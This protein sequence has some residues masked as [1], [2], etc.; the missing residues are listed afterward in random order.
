MRPFLGKTSIAVL[1]CLPFSGQI[2]HASGWNGSYSAQGQCYCIGELSL[3]LSGKIVPTPV[4]G[5]TISQVCKRVGDGPEL[6]RA[7]GL[8]NFPVYEDPQCGNGPYASGEAP[9]DITCAGSLD[10]EGDS[11]EA[12]GPKWDLDQAFS[13]VSS[14]AAVQPLVE[15]DT[16]IEGVLINPVVSSVEVENNKA[17]VG[18]KKTLKATIIK[19]QSTAGN[20][21]DPGESSPKNSNAIAIEAFTGKSVT[22]DGQRYLQANSEVPAS[23][24]KP[25]SR[26]ILDDLV[27]LREDAFLDPSDL[28]QNE[29]KPSSAVTAAVKA[30]PKVAK[31]S[32]DELATTR[33]IESKRTM[34]LALKA[35]NARRDERVAIKAPA[36]AQL[37]LQTKIAATQKAEL[38][39]QADLNVQAEQ[40][41]KDTQVLNEAETEQ[42]LLKAQA[43]Q[44]QREKEISLKADA[45][46]VQKNKQALLNAEAEQARKNREAQ[47]LAA[48]KQRQKAVDGATAQVKPA[49]SVGSPSA[50]DA[51]SSDNVS[52]LLTALRL[53][54][55]VRQSARDFGYLEAMPVSYDVGGNGV[56]LE[57]SASSHTRFQYVGRLS[58]TAGYQEV[59]I[60]G[61]YYIT[62]SVADRLTV[63]LVAGLEYGSFELSDDQLSVDFDDSGVY[64]GAATRIVLNERFELKGGV[65]YSTFFE[66]DPMLFGGGYYHINRRLDVVSRFELGDNDLLGIGVRF[67]Y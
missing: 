47:R 9:Q 5:Q 20:S 10:G 48:E 16:S 64:L 14:S 63:V 56:L 31:P 2:A 29:Q 18:E 30:E 22:L 26:I 52:T 35:Q 62:P 65:G 36:E 49:G 41:Q 55:D 19:S 1:L 27:F 34:L 40:A 67:Y 66:G 54:P 24:G 46:Q 57:G 11:C 53:P 8:F 45:E 32:A 17:N 33:Q 44:A 12:V 59:M 25:G 3:T 21:F 50:S 28:Y 51:N 38:D 23:G 58:V 37:T 39:R 15:N 13:K 4:G 7:S 60:G 61:G 42:A 6:L 43:E